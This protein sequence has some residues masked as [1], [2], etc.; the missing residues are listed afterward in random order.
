MKVN[1]AK[2]RLPSEYQEV[3]W[4]GSDGNQWLQT[5]AVAPSALDGIEIHANVSYN[6]LPDGSSDNQIQSYLG[7]M[8]QGAHASNVMGVTL[9]YTDSVWGSQFVYGGYGMLYGASISNPSSLINRELMMSYKC[10]KN[11]IMNS[12]IIDKLTGEIYYSSV[13]RDASGSYRADIDNYTFSLFRA[14]STF[15]TLNSTYTFSGKIY[16]LQILNDNTRQVILDV[17]PCYRKSDNEIGMYDLVTNT[18]FTNQGT[19]TFSKGNDV[20]PVV[21]P[22]KVRQMNYTPHFLPSEYQEVEWI[23]FGSFGDVYI[24]TGINNSTNT[25]TV[26]LDIDAYNVDVSGSTN[27]KFIIKPYNAGTQYYSIVRYSNTYLIAFMTSSGQ[28]A[29]NYVN[30]R[31]VLYVSPTIIKINGETKATP[32]G[33]ASNYNILLGCNGYDNNTSV[34]KNTK[35]WGMKM[36]KDSIL[37]RNFIPCYRKSDN[38]IGMYDLVNN[39]FYSNAGTGTFTKGPD[40]VPIK[41]KIRR[42]PR[43]PMEYQEVEWIGNPDQAY[44][45]TSFNCKD[46]D[47]AELKFFIT[48]NRTWANIFG[49]S[50]NNSDPHNGKSICVSNRGQV[51]YQYDSVRYFDKPNLTANNLY[52]AKFTAKIG[53]Q[54]LIINDELIGETNISSDISGNPP[55]GIFSMWYGSDAGKTPGESTIANIYYTRLYN[56][57][58]L[59][60][61]FIPCYRKS[62]NEI[63]MYDLVTNTF[64][65]NAGTGTFTKGPDVIY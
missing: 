25:T 49:G 23:G 17:V 9:V 53:N 63:G 52:V 3:E 35:I 57:D 61:D 47:Y 39:Q 26:E 1:Y 16:S 44:I 45:K 58:A 32:S 62:D 38:E 48:A 65:T 54:K 31:M 14:K 29:F 11:H 19:G 8:T 6:K 56:N 59:I 21:I 12:S 36:T 64:Y 2:V 41:M 7:T 5:N 33:V 60:G 30:G 28:N 46:F 50:T 55:V 40:V 4:I 15:L 43:L 51:A 20:L 18:F 10:D 22:C 42:P 27:N 37:V 34:P 13:N 24:D